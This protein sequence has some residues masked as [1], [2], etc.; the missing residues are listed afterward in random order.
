MSV[1]GK[2]K[3]RARGTGS[4]F[5]S[6]ARGLWVGRVPRGKLPSGNTRYQEITDSSQKKL[7]ERLKELR[8]PGADTTVAEWAERWHKSLTIRESSRAGY[9]YTLDM[10][11]YPTLGDLAVAELTTADCQDAVRQ[12]STRVGASTVRLCLAHLRICLN[13]ARRAGLIAASPATDVRTPRPVRR[14]IEPIPPADLARVTVACITSRELPIALLA[15]T[16][17]RVGEA[18]ALNVEDYDR[19]AG[20]IAISRTWDRKYGMRAPKSENSRRVIRVPKAARAAIGLAAG[21]RTTGPLFVAWGRSERRGH[22]SVRCAWN[23]IQKRLGLTPRRN[24]HQLRHSVASSLVAAGAPIADVAAYIGDTVETVVATYLHPTKT[25]PS[26][27][28]DTLLGGGKVSASPKK[29][30]KRA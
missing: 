10:F 27:V 17:C 19:A 18:L 6:D 14:Q 1:M 12:W 30:R 4:I 28:M 8:P 13:A 9:R 3:R 23:A 22:E 7:I 5:W 20:T 24:V 15:T 2:S 16:G 29:S 26:A 11:V 25:D 21:N